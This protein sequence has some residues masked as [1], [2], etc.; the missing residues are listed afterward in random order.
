MIIGIVGSEAAKFTS[1]GSFAARSAIFELVHKAGITG[2]ASGDCHL[3][4]VDEWARITAE[5]VGLPFYGFPPEHLRWEPNGYKSR[6]IKIARKCDEMVCISVDQYP[7]D[8]AENR[9]SHCY[10]C[11]QPLLP[12][13]PHHIK[14]GGCWT[15]WFAHSLGKP[16]SLI[17]IP[18]YRGDP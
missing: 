10:H 18:N 15:R 1:R 8:F 4:G 2:V 14:S 16:T 6:N 3:G 5:I 13:Q 12:Q 9:Y 17:I 11:E 7:S